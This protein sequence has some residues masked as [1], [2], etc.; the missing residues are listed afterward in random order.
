MNK[1]FSPPDAASLTPMMQQYFNLK[2]QAGDDVLLMFRMGDFYE[3]FYDDAQLASRILNLTLTKRGHTGGNDIPMAG[4]PVQSL[5]QYLSRL[6]A[7]GLSVAIGE[8]VGD[9]ASSKG[10]VERK[11]VRI[12]TPGTITDENLLPQKSDSLILCIY[13]KGV[14]SGITWLNLANGDFASSE[15]L[16]KSLD[17]ELY[18]LSPAEIIVPESSNYKFSYKCTITKVPDWHFDLKEC[19]L[20]LKEFFK[21]DD[22]SVF[23]L[24]VEASLNIISAGCLLRYIVKTQN[25]NL[26]HIKKIY[27]E[28]ES[29]FLGLDP[30]TRKNLELTES[31]SSSKGPTLF[32]T[33]DN[34][35]TGMGSR[36][37]RNWIHNPLKNNSEINERQTNVS[38]FLQPTNEEF[39]ISQILKTLKDQLKPI[40]DIERLSSRVAMLTI[41]PKELAKLR[42]SLHTLE[43]VRKFLL[44]NYGNLSINLECIPKAEELKEYLSRAIATE[45]STQIRDGGVIAKGF[46]AELDD[47]RNTSSNNGSFLLEYETKLKEATGISLLRVE[48]N[49]VQGFFIEIPKSRAENVPDTFRR[50][51]TLKNVERFTTPELKQ[52]EDKILSADERALKR[53]KYL[54]DE[55]LQ[56]IQ[57]WVSLLQDIAKLVASI[58]VYSAL[59]YHAYNNNWIKPEL[60]EGTSIAI[61]QGRHPVVERTIEKFTANDCFLNSENRMQ[62]ITGPNMGGKSTYM[63][64]TALIVLLA[65]MGS[66]VPAESASIGEVDAIFTR[67][68][69]S[70]DLAGGRSTFMVEMIEAAS[71]LTNST[72]GS[73]VLMDEIGRGTSTYDGLSLAW[74]IAC[75]L[76]N[77]NKSLT[78]FATHYFELTRLVD[79][80]KGIANVHL[81]AVE[82]SDGL[83]FM[84]EVHDGPANKSYGIQVAQK[85]GLPMAVIKQAQNVLERLN[86]SN[87]SQMDLFDTQVSD[88]DVSF[89]DPAETRDKFKNLQDFISDIDPDELSPR[90]ALETLY[91]LKDFSSNI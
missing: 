45:P 54:Y 67:I 91:R 61:E 87:S 5:D 70:D 19:T 68:G 25:E 82:T 62:I 72:N 38:Q 32:S 63:R 85:A 55:I 65:R 9:P 4:I 76:L 16:S 89:E 15:I 66:Y 10:P 3:M 18:R 30:F 47:L 14:H 83:V 74:A 11:L 73:L 90:E 22:L 33:L 21:I 52:W 59:A 53:E 27:I 12:I 46:D 1:K 78:L 28:S 8:Q 88:I 29:R 41:K 20:R 50:K 81:S 6:V 13:S 58:D 40:T 64:Q 79:E 36:L 26:G 39:S 80:Y 31:L 43:V 84:H 86:Q 57:I 7:S 51:Q 37:L 75:R 69:A 24:G 48:Y 49:R 44:E 35:E 56:N 60:V 42:D 17:Q 34:C 23:G 71:I 2:S 77:H